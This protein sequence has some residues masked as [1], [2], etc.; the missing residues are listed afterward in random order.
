MAIVVSVLLHLWTITSEKAVSTTRNSSYGVWS[1]HRLYTSRPKQGPL[2]GLTVPTPVTL[3]SV[4]LRRTSTVLLTAMTFISWPLVLIIGTVRKL[5]PLNRPEILLRLAAASMSIIPELTRLPT[6]L[7][8]PPVSISVC[9]DIMLTS[10][11]SLLA[12]Q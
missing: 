4:L 1:P 10:S 11:W 8:A 2:E 6:G 9:R 12:I 3:L 5:H 7:L